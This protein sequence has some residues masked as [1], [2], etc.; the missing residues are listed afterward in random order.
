MIDAAY[1]QAKSAL[2]AKIFSLHM[3]Q[4][5]PLMKGIPSNIC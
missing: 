3:H 2:L 1:L 5:L 4:Y